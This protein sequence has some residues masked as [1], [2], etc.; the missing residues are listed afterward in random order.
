MQDDAQAM[1]G[2]L[3]EKR[4]RSTPPLAPG[5]TPPSREGLL[6]T[7]TFSESSLTSLAETIHHSGIN[8]E[9]SQEE[10][11]VEGKESGVRLK[12]VVEFAPSSSSGNVYFRS[13]V[14]SRQHCRLIRK[15]DKVSNCILHEVSSNY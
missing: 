11:R 5:A 10:S 8:P 1:V 14:I 3:M 13:K 15:E 6:L 12:V 9:A 7:P 4:I 2:R